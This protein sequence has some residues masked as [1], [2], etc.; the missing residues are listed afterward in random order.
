MALR[1][2]ASHAAAE[3]ARLGAELGEARAREAAAR[4]ETLAARAAGAGDAS[5]AVAAAR[6]EAASAAERAAV[7]EAAATEARAAAERARRE[8]AELRAA[9][10]ASFTEV[11]TSQRALMVAERGASEA[12]AALAAA[13]GELRAAREEEAGARAAARVQV[14]E[15]EAAAA[16]AEARVLAAQEELARTRAQLRVAERALASSRALAVEQQTELER[17][18]LSAGAT[19]GLTG[20]VGAHAHAATP[21]SAL[22]S[23]ASPVAG[24]LDAVR[25]DLGPTLDAGAGPGPGARLR[26]GE[27]DQGGLQDVRAALAARDEEIA[28]LR[29]TVDALLASSRPSRPSRAAAAPAPMASTVEV[30][31]MFDALSRMPSDIAS[32][33]G[34]AGA[35]GPSGAPATR[36]GATAPELRT[37][38]GAQADPTAPASA[39]SAS[40]SPSSDSSDAAVLSSL[41]EAEDALTR[42]LADRNEVLARAER[43]EGALGA[44]LADSA[45]LRAQLAA[46]S[47]GS[48]SAGDAWVLE[49]E[50][51]EVRVQ[52]LR[53]GEERLGEEAARGRARCEELEATVARLMKVTGGAARGWLTGMGGGVAMATR[54]RL[55]SL[56]CRAAATRLLR[57]LSTQTGLA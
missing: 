29:A 50:A 37:L 7:A 47:G 15:T 26:H 33:V 17:S 18:G 52:E 8:G 51:M 43:A 16:A 56:P 30:P 4:A 44:A 28:R 9:L 39:R 23:V 25:R 34:D 27:S 57:W 2:E 31:T 24:E 6:A 36:H 1:G 5:P 21:D 11:A 38:P 55:L 13:A 20:R 46:K 40:S 32:R 54:A 41:V 22:R 3:L 12:R 53:A 35:E 14:A 10:E 45:A 48:G 19:P 42:G 49:R